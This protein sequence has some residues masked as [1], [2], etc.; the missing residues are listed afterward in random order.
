MDTVLENKILTH[1]AI[2]DVSLSNLRPQVGVFLRR[3]DPELAAS[4]LDAVG[5]GGVVLKLADRQRGCGVVA[6]EPA[7][8]E[9]TLRV[10]LVCPEYA[11]PLPIPH[12]ANGQITAGWA[13]VAHKAAGLGGLEEAAAHWHANEC[14]SF[15]AEALCKSKLTEG[16]GGE[17]YDGTLR[18]GFALEEERIQFLGAYWKLPDTPVDRTQDALSARVVSHTHGGSGTA[19]CSKADEAAVWAVL[20]EPLLKIFSAGARKFTVPGLMNRYRDSPLFAATALTRVAA[21]LIEED[22]AKAERT[23]LLAEQ[24][25]GGGERPLSDYVCSYVRRTQGTLSARRA[26]GAPD[27]RA[28]ATFYDEAVQLMPRNA[29]ALYFAGMVRL[30]RGSYSMAGHYFARSVAADGD[31]AC[32]YNQLATCCLLLGDFGSCVEVAEALLQ[33]HN[34]IAAAHH[35]IAVAL[36]GREASSNERGGGCDAERRGRAAAALRRARELQRGKSWGQNEDDMLE[37]LQGD[38]PL[39]KKPART[40][41]FHAWRL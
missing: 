17:L 29:A 9:E 4:I 20:E 19:A 25:A 27:W 18:I 32:A 13:T 30:T 1:D 24:L 28:A 3:H 16:P 33:R 34:R 39:P 31:Y 8:L 36:Y 7:D 37:A 26:G 15:L 21:G 11:E 6:V 2:A 40:W 41:L 12:S 35:H 23:L 22:M 5:R 14:P 38:A 10:L